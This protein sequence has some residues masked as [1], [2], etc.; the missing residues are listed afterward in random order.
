[1]YRSCR[2][3]KYDW[4]RFALKVNGMSEIFVTIQDILPA[5]HDLIVDAIYFGMPCSP[6][7]VEARRHQ[8]R[9][10]SA[11]TGATKEGHVYTVRKLRNEGN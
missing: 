1:M 7:L 10:N 11:E 8:F 2:S 9:E 5:D 3:V 6:A 4:L